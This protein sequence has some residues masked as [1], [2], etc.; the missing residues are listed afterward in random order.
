[1]NVTMINIT[2]AGSLPENE[3]VNVRLLN[4][5]NLDGA[6]DSGDTQ[7]GPALNS[8]AS[9]MYRFTTINFVVPIGTVSL[10]VLVNSTEN[11][12]ANRVFS[13]SL[14]GTQDINS[15]GG[16]SGINI[17]E[18][19]TTAVSN[20]VSMDLTT[21]LIAATGPASDEN[22]TA[23]RPALLVNTSEAATCKFDTSD[24]SYSTMRNTFTGT[25]ATHNYTLSTQRDGTTT[26]YVRCQDTGGNTMTSS[27]VIRFTVDTRASFNITRPSELGNYWAIGWNTFT[28]PK[29]QVLNETGLREFNVTNVTT[30]VSGKFDK[31]LYNPGD[32]DSTWLSYIPDRV[33]NS[34]AVFNDTTGSK[35]YW[36]KINVSNSRLEIN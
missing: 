18:T 21:P 30:S 9:S 32:S 24:R 1:M 22:V 2:R 20:N 25:S 8:T 35:P 26:F 19:I 4:D 28:L 16:V 14:A 33:V 5:T 15:V 27:S 7:V 3:L 31:L 10:L 23:S 13:L 29:S 34:L 11:G 12:T 17:T 6:F 36:M